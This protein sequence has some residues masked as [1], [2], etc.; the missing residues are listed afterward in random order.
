MKKLILILTLLISITASAGWGNGNGNG[1]GNGHGNE[2]GMK[3]GDDDHDNGGGNDDEPNA[4]IGFGVMGGLVIGLLVVGVFVYLLPSDK[5]WTDSRK[6]IRSIADIAKIIEAKNEEFLQMTPAQKRV[7][8]A[9]DLIARVRLKQ[10]V[11]GKSRIVHLKYGGA[12]AEANYEDSVKDILNSTDENVCQVCA[13]GGLLMSYIGRVNGETRGDLSELNGYNSNSIENPAHKK[14]LELFD[15]RQLSYIE[16]AFEGNKY[17]N[18]DE[19]REPIVFTA[20]EME[21]ALAFYSKYENDSNKRLI[22]ISEN[23]I[24]NNGTFIL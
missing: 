8:I 14:L 9:N 16:L 3:D 11:A 4:P 7:E 15:A 13:K 18:Y 23:I 1:N 19:K 6:E 5:E 2:G 21:A 10:F 17:L 12:L 22:A 20:E 24:T